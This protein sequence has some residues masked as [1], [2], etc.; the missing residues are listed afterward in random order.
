[1]ENK[2]ELKSTANR[3]VSDLA[4]G[5]K[6]IQLVSG[7]FYFIVGDKLRNLEQPAINQLIEDGAL[8]KTF[9]HRRKPVF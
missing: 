7:Q 5:K 1:M 3:I 4:K 9:T 2:I 8:R 6:L